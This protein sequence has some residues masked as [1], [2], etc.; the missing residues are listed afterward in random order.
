MGARPQVAA[1]PRS[2]RRPL[3]P[4]V[5]ALV[6][7][8]A[9][10]IGVAAAQEDQPDLRSLGGGAPG[11]ISADEITYDE[12]RGL[13]SAIGRV[14][15]VQGERTLL[16]DSVSYDLGSKTVVA[17]GNVALIDPDGT[18]LFADHV[19]LTEDL[20]EGFI[21]NIGVLMKEQIRIA[22][23]TGVRREGNLTTFR[24]AVYSPCKLCREDS[25]RA[26]L[27]QLKAD[28][29]VHDQEAQT[30]TYRDVRLEFFGVPVL[31]SPFFRHP[32]PFVD[33]QSGFLAPSFGISGQLGATAQLSYY[34]N[35]APDKDATFEPLFTTKQSIVLA[36]QYRELFANG[37]FEFNGS[38]TI[39]DRDTGSRN[40]RDQFRGH[41]ESFGRFDIDETW[42][43]GFDANRATDDT[44]L[45]LYNFSS[46]S[47]LT[48]D[49]FLEG[50]SG[51]NYAALKSFAFQGLRE[52]DNDKELP[53]VLPLIEYDYVSEPDALG[54][55]FSLEPGLAVLTR[56]KGRDTRRLSMQA[57]WE[58]PFIGPI[59]DTY[60]L[61]ANLLAA[62][63]W[64]DDFDSDST[65][66]DPPNG[67]S[68]VVGRV[69][70]QLALEWRYPLIQSL[71]WADQ[72]VEPIVQL[73]AA[74]DSANNG[75]IPNEDSLDF[76][77]DDTNL[78]SL[79]RFTGI[80]RV[81][82]GS[83]IDYAFKW[84]LFSPYLGEANAFVGQSFRLEKDNAFRSDSGLDD[85]LSDIVGRI[86]LQP[87]EDI[88]LSYRFRFDQD[89]LSA[90]RNEIDL[91][92]GP[93]ALN[94]DLSYVFLSDDPAT[95][96]FDEREEIDFTASAQISRYW[97]IFGRHLR[98][99]EADRS[100]ETAFGI[101]YEDE[102]FLASL[103][104]KRTEFRDREVEDDDSVMVKVVFKPYG[105]G[106]GS[107]AS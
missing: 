58:A 52:E 41:I 30:I 62:G 53:I 54:G 5:L 57:G 95:A 88:A 107:G 26:P 48:S 20:R 90:E 80:D 83:R 24:K 64:V 50:L 82:P 76:E 106:C 65:A 9:A 74:P 4:L 69:F 44:Y 100:L 73:V 60:R 27:W 31:Y 16:A 99:L 36:G 86:G 85:Q 56:I 34:W 59:G 49:L 81:D 45:R 102:C 67:H 38:A 39:A 42:R 68:E 12:A 61:K 92:L 3:A 32:D 63:Y 104:G 66:V 89:D 8:V 84:T 103:V 15:I 7:A 2:S 78:L 37:E 22:A 55:R 46:A 79:N 1:R 87:H 98:D 35:I 23:V 43:W 71:S 19:E 6:L 17:S 94:L 77:F 101:A 33:R 70:P 28:R 11:L 47:T 91:N 96:E 10:A 13:V 105:G 29:V 25:Q 75:D 97:S 40:K 72:V 18:V 21:R 51:R 14:E 93:P